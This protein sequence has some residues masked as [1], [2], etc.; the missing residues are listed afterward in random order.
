MGIIKCRVKDCQNMGILVRGWCSSHYHRWYRYGDPLGK[1]LKE[2]KVIVEDLS[3]DLR[4]TITTCIVEDCHNLV[5]NIPYTKGPIKR[6]CGKTCSN[7]QSYINRK[8]VDPEHFKKWDRE[9]GF[10]RYGITEEEYN[11]ILEAQNGGC[12]VCC[13]KTPGGVGRFHVDHDHKC[14]PSGKSCGM[15]VRGLLCSRC[16]TAAGLLQDDPTIVLALLEYIEK[17]SQ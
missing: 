6:F 17:R 12:A 4:T 5:V 7:R 9:R 1:S 2:E 13:S 14:C 8:M 16:N 15:C 10:S 3:I 11:D